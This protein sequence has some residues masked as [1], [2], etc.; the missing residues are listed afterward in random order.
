MVVD[1]GAG[2]KLLG[3]VTR[4]TETREADEAGALCSKGEKRKA[5]VPECQVPESNCQVGL[6]R[7]TEASSANRAED[8]ERS[9]RRRR[10]R[11]AGR[12]RRREQGRREA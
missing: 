7:M 5:R 6:R 10:R 11:G 3:G 2:K 12:A 1:P 8:S 9:E 4:E